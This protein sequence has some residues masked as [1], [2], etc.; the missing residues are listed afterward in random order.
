MMVEEISL[1]VLEARQD[2]INKGIIRMDSQAF[3]DLGVSPGDVVELMGDRKTVAIAARAFPADIGL[4]VV[5]MDGLTRRNAGTSLGELVKIRKADAKPAKRVVIAPAQK[6]VH[7]QVLGPTNT[8]KRALL[9]RPIVKGDVITLGGTSERRRAFSGNPFEDI[10]RMIE[11]DPFIG[12]PFGFAGMRFVVVSTQPKSSVIITNKTDVVL[13]PEAV[14]VE[15]ENLPDITYEDIGGLKEE[16]TKVREMIELP[17]KH[18]ELFQRL[19]IEPPKGVLLYGPPGTG[20]T[21][22][23]KAVANE[24][25]AHFI[26]INGPE[27][28][29]KWVG[30]AEKKL[31][32]VFEEA[33]EN[34]PSI[35]F[36]DEIDSIAPKREDVT[37][38]VERRVVAQLLTSMDGLSGRGQVIVIGAT[39]RENSI[40]PALRRPGRFDRE[41]EIGVPDRQGRLEIFKIHTRNMPLDKSVDLE[42][43]ASIT[44]GFVGADIAAVCKEAAM[45]ALRRFLPEIKEAESRDED[46][47]PAEVLEKITVTMS[48]FRSALKIVSPSAMREVMIESPNVKWSDIGGL[49]VVKREL[50]ESVEWP[51]KYPESFKRLGIKPPKGILLYGPPGCGKTLLAKAVATESEAN[52]IS[53]K[54]PEVLSKWVGESERKIRE[55]FRKAKQ[56][57]PSV[58]FFD[59]FDSIVPK[60]GGDDGGSRISERL[61]NQILTELDGV[62]ELND[63]VVI[64][65]TN[66]P[67]MVDDA[68]LRPGRFDKLI[69]VPPPDLE[70]RKQ[71]FRVHMK[72]VPVSDDV[73]VD[74]L[75]ARTEGYSGADIQAVVREAALIALR[76]NKDAKVVTKKDF[77]KALL[78]VRSSVSDELVKF[79]EEFSER[80]HKKPMTRSKD[81]RY[82]G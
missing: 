5:R 66:R 3:K 33:E 70:A 23:A 51:L 31:R 2:D 73:S 26:S 50:R 27:V 24:T 29:S 76:R 19:G 28:M 69:L 68:L 53:V 35:I 58:V 6:G 61:V 13:K 21:L 55:I 67:D 52:F 49:E 63:V 64:A 48:D 77:D 43:L 34:A 18:P 22:L 40:D 20:K 44:H 60:R 46:K 57:S 39:N 9:G 37:G 10:F 72:N 7:I 14:N 71:I 80:L 47:L 30:E 62:E 32:K 75:A 1:K 11:G 15:A 81:K 45:L 54:G 36:I 25:N 12:V 82:L 41:I 74:D 79:Y 42:R 59:E 56:V 38:E 4:G 16:I 8:I 78:E 65:A 17:L